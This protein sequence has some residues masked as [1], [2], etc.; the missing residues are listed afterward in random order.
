MEKTEM[1]KTFSIEGVTVKIAAENLPDSVVAAAKETAKN[2]WQF[3]NVKKSVL[4]LK[5]ANA[6]EEAAEKGKVGLIEFFA[7]K[8]DLEKERL[9][10]FAEFDAASTRQF[11]ESIED[12]LGQKHKVTFAVG[13]EF[14]KKPFMSNLEAYRK[15]LPFTSSELSK[16]TLRGYVAK[17]KQHGSFRNFEPDDLEG[18]KNWIS[19]IDLQRDLPALHKLTR[20]LQDTAEKYRGKLVTDTGEKL[21]EVLIHALP[22]VEADFKKAASDPSMSPRG[23]ILGD[24]VADARLAVT[25]NELAEEAYMTTQRM[26]QEN[27]KGESFFSTLK[28][29]LFNRHEGILLGPD[30]YVKNEHE[31][32][33]SDKAPKRE[34]NKKWL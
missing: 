8:T 5:K 31:E 26:E 1:E 33:F 23:T 13:D 3:A 10:T 19:T 34:V 24:Q 18:F 21:L 16:R 2:R 11:T 4:Y 30:D 12:D 20:A 29:Q 28:K 22:D 14:E 32:G 7:L 9:N 6:L 27:E 25:L 17:E 15:P